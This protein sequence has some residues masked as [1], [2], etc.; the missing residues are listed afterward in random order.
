MS[1]AIIRPKRVF[2]YNG[3]TFQD[4]DASMT[5]QEVVEEYAKNYPYLQFVTIGE[6]EIS[7]DGSEVTY[8][9]EQPAAKTKGKGA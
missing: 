9:L 3:M 1:A 6:P 8:E 7:K 4:V 5:P 2:K